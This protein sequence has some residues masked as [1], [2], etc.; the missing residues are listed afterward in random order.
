MQER[1][2]SLASELPPIVLMQSYPPCSLQPN[3]KAQERHISYFALAL[4]DFPAMVIILSKMRCRV[5]TAKDC[6]EIQLSD[7]HFVTSL[8]LDPLRSEVAGRR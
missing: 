4:T 8:R 2:H 3:A 7:G 1:H 5:L 6:A